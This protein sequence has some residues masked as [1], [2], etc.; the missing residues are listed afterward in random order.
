M[1]I[2]LPVFVFSFLKEFHRI[3][4]FCF[5]MPGKTWQQEFAIKYCVYSVVQ[6]VLHCIFVFGGVSVDMWQFAFEERNLLFFLRELI[7]PFIG[8][9][10]VENVLLMLVCRFAVRF[11]IRDFW[12][13]FLWGLLFGGLH[14]IEHNI[15]YIHSIF[16]FW[17][18]TG[19]YLSWY[20]SKNAF[21]IILLFHGLWNFNVTVFLMLFGRFFEYWVG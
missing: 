19:M 18:M 15:S 21:L 6:G 2:A 17:I 5:L 10:F 9:A 16:S 4:T 7:P 1:K 8:G 20:R 14:I 11:H 12:T 3:F 13:V